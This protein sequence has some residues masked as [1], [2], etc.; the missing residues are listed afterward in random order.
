MP[1]STGFDELLE[2]R[3]FELLERMRSTPIAEV[4]E[5]LNSLS[6]V[7]NEYRLNDELLENFLSH[8]TPQYK[9]QLIQETLR[10]QATKVKKSA[11]E[12]QRLHE[13]SHSILEHSAQLLAKIDRQLYELTH[14]NSDYAPEI[15]ANCGGIGSVNCKMC[16]SCNGRRTIL[17]HQPSIKCPRCVGTGRSGIRDRLD[18]SQYLCVICRGRGWVLILDQ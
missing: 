9:S 2:S 8:T 11:A 3:L 12:L 18:F 7:V 5:E 17:V 1:A 6:K 10:R 16:I 14:K 4:E 13:K 15:C